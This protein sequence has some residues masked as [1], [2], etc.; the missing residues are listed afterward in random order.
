MLIALNLFAVSCSCL[1]FALNMFLKCFNIVYLAWEG[2][3][4]AGLG[5]IMAK[6]FQSL[7]DYDFDA[8]I[9]AI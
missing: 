5:K 7:L 1:L 9:V 6:R 8:I 2:H 4:K 3:I